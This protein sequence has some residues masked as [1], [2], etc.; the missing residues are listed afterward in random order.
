MQR[1]EA[2]FT[3]LERLIRDERGMEALQAIVIAAVGIAIVYGGWLLIK[4]PITNFFGS[5]SSWL[6][7][8]S[9]T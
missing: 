8:Q 5:V 4:G 1:R 3:M 6:T 9:P 7:Q 2:F